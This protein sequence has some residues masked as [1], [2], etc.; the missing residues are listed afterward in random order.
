MEELIRKA[1]SGDTEAY[2]EVM[3]S[4][5]N[6][7]YRIAKTRLDNENDIYDAIYETTLKS[8]KNLKKLK[9]IEFFKT[10]VIRILI[11]ECNKIYNTN[12]KH[13]KLIEKLSVVEESNYIDD[14]ISNLNFES[15]ISILN[16]E[17]RI[18]FTLY[19]HD[20]YTPTEIAKILNVSV[21]TIKSRLK[22]GKEKLQE[23][24]IGGVEYDK[25]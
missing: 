4:I 18:V 7:L 2:A 3:E 11:N 14:T 20:R 6:T 16:Y 25:Q 13:L 5:Q 10:W 1:I 21:N 23:K 17:E 9:N 19:F 8:F 22:R 24:L 12:M 15:L